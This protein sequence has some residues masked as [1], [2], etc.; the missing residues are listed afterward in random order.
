MKCIDAIEGTVKCIINQW[1][2]LC[3]EHR[4]EDSEYVRNVKSVIDGTRHFLDDNPEVVE[5]PQ[6]L[7]EVLY[8]YSRERWLSCQL[9]P[10][11]EAVN[12]APPDAETQE[13]RT[14]FYDYL[15]HRGIYPR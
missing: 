6:L 7:F 3:V 15:Y 9:S 5:N 10:D 8:D 12:I 1:H 2:E 13:Y 11:D 4:L 14:Y